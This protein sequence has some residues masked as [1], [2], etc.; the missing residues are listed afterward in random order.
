M[1]SARRFGF[2]VER[3][4]AIVP[5]AD[6]YMRY[7]RKVS[8]TSSPAVWAVGPLGKLGKESHIQRPKAHVFLELSS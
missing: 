8:G 6:P 1:V 2:G 3:V 4:R 7:C 5:T